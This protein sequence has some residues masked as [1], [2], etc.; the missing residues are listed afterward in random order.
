MSKVITI[1][2]SEAGPCKLDALRLVDSRALIQANSGGG[3]SWLLRVIAE[4][5]AGKLPTIILDPEGEFATLREKVDMILV[6]REGEIRP[7]VR[8]A[9]LLARKLFELNVS[10][11]VD[12][13]DL[14]LDARRE[15]VKGF[16]D[17]LLNVPREQWHPM[18]VAIDECHLFAPERSAGEAASTEAVIALASQGRKRGIGLIALTQRL[19]KLH[20]DAA[21]E[22]NN[23]FIGRT[24][25]PNDQE[26]CGDL[27]GMKKSERSMLRDLAPGEFY[28]FGPALNCNG[29]VKFKSSPVETTHP[30]AGDRHR[31]EPPKASKV[32]QEIAAALADLPQQAE[33]EIKDVA[34]AQAKI[35]ELER[36]LQTTAK[37]PPAAPREDSPSA[38]QLKQQAVIIARLRKGLEETM[39]VIAE[40]S[41]KGFEATGIDPG[42]VRKAIE[43]AT[44]QIVKIAEQRLTQRQSEFEKL[45]KEMSQLLAKLQKLIGE[46]V[47]VQVNVQ[48]NEPFT[49]KSKETASP[50]SSRADGPV[51][52]GLNGPQQAI[53]DTV[54]MLEARGIVASRDS[55]ARW[56]DIH[57]NGGSYGTNLGRLRTDGYL[58]GFALTDLGRSVAREKATGMDAALIALP[59]E[60]K[61]AIV[62]TLVDAGHP[63]TRDEL[64][65]ALNLH[66]NGGSFGTNIGRLRT[67][68]LITERGP[69]A[70][71]DALAR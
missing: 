30:K 49:V 61:R 8:S 53:L 55:V 25:L 24:W 13:Y 66:P 11:V 31:I 47:S 48:H 21:A 57:P 5:V 67:M 70:P 64:A 9:G 36:A 51:A 60:P 42:E 62:R 43:A 6:G 63:L 56:L 41:A 38:T 40:I 16:C 69:I 20:K 39:K 2:H 33:A 23:V 15:F 7:D 27:L 12:L 59:D 14:R 52:D 17:A 10:A 68:G 54:L 22:L 29:V 4:Q 45:R 1:G 32:I 19:S 50:R 44:T 37:S 65:T 71:T 46:D 18:L 58:E 35:R 28:G 26:R 3:K 34:A